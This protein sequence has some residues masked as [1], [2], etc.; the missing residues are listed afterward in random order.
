MPTSANRPDA[1]LGSAVALAIA[2][3]GFLA[4]MHARPGRP[5]VVVWY[6]APTAIALTAAVL[7]GVALVR[8]WRQRHLPATRDLAGF[9]ALAMVVA[10]L[11][12]FRSYPSSHD[13]RP[14]RV[15]FRLPLDGPV[16]VAWGG[17]TPSVNYHAVMPDQRW[18]YDL[19]VTMDARTFRGDGARL[20]D[21]YA[22][23]QPVRA[24]AAGVVR[25]VHDG[26]P[27]GPIGHWQFLGAH[28]NHVVVEVAPSEFLFIAH[29]QP[30]SILVAPGDRIEADQPI[31]RVGNSGNSSEPHV[32]LH[33]QDSA[34]PFLGEGIPMYFHGYRTGGVE[35]ARG[36][37]TG[38]RERRSRMFPGAF[39]G[40]I[41]ERTGPS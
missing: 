25:A 40:E 27:E 33:L 4:F 39:T 30:G 34:T 6:V 32:H 41:V 3:A 38:G 10:S 11:V 26:E 12:A 23:G 2:H 16:T 19:L 7:L 37:P 5:A 21:Y 15:E 17:A 18:A 14:S 35:I 29:L 22:Y 9:A 13:S 8:S 1:W 24:P 20:D 28:G 31:G 36:M